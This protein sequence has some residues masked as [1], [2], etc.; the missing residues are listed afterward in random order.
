VDDRT[1]LVRDVAQVLDGVEQARSLAFVNDRPAIALDVQKQAGA[2][3]VG[4]AD[5]VRAAVASMTP[6]LPPGVSLQLVRDDS[7]FIRES[8]EDVQVTLVLGGCSRSL[9]SSSSSTRGDRP[10][11]PV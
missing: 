1:L 5:G 9:S 8:I 11:S 4:V 2:N 3:T 10:S 6:E 7:T